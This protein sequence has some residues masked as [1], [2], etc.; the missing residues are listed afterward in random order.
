MSV[1]KRSGRCRCPRP[2][3]VI[4]G[5]VSS[6]CP[7]RSVGRVHMSHLGDPLKSER[8]G[9]RSRRH[10]A[11]LRSQGISSSSR[12]FV[13][14]LCEFTCPSMSSGGRE[15]KVERRPGGEN[16]PARLSEEHRPGFCGSQRFIAQ[17]RVDW[18][19]RSNRSCCSIRTGRTTLGDHG[20]DQCL[21]RRVARWDDDCI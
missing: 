4:R 6:G 21:R 10:R 16:F 13:L 11:S 9:C 14:S 20:G 3:H 17:R 5:N 12:R 1:I 8:N 18:E 15:Y 2:L 7:S 19:R